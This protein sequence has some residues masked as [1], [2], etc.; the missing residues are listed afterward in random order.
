MSFQG[1]DVTFDF[2]EV[3]RFGGTLDAVAQRQL[4]FAI[5]RTL[6]A[7]AKKAV[8]DDL[9]AAM[10]SAFDKPTPYTLRVLAFLPATKTKLQAQILPRAF[11]G[12]GN[13]AW[14]YLDPEV[15]GAPRGA[16]RG[17]KRLQALL[18]G[19][20]FLIPAKGTKLDSYGNVS[21][22]QMVKIL[23]GLGALIDRAQN[24][25]AKSAKRSKRLVARHGKR[26]NNSQY[27]VGRSRSTSKRVSLAKGKPI[28]IY[29]LK[30][31]GR[32]VPVLVISPRPP[33]YRP[34]FAFGPVVA[35]S[36]AASMPAFFATYLEDAV[37]TAR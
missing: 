37:R 26:R 23:S 4:P 18:G 29:E 11:A 12:K 34:R 19:P 24:A 21:R 33:K 35:R 1:F 22:G 10:K 16:K 14:Q 13:V 28:A 31:K 25:T 3:A 15:V 5:A 20:A 9:P 36:V 8:A 6:T 7:S 30:G 32:V 17:E 2:G 27:F